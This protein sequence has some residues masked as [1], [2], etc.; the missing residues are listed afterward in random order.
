MHGYTPGR[1]SFNVKGGRC[2]ACEGD[3]VKQRRDALPARR[4]R[5]VRG[6]P[7]PALQRRDA[8]REV[9]R[10]LDRRR[11]RPHGRRGAAALQEPPEPSAARSRRSPTWA[12]ATSPS[13]SP[14]RRSPAARRSASSSRASS[15]KRSTGRTLYILDE[16]TTGL[17]FDDIR[18]LLRV[19]DRL[20]EA[21]NTVVVIEHNLDVIKTADWVIDLG[22]EGGDG[23]GSDRRRGHAGAGGGGEGL[24]TPAASSRRCCRETAAAGARERRIAPRRRRLDEKTVARPRT[25]GLARPARG[26]R[27]RAGPGPA[28]AD[29][30]AAGV[31]GARAPRV[32][33]DGWIQLRINGAPR[34]RGFQHGFLLAKEIDASLRTTR[35]RWQYRTGMTWPWLVRRSE[36]MFRGRID[37]ELRAEIDGIVGR[38]RRGRGF[39]ERGRAGGVQRASSSFPATGGRR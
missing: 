12:S 35:R 3:G 26:P 5:A 8:R 31:A 19:L 13:A 10:P 7:R 34:E 29:A 15:S 2:E 4:L 16:P 30:A 32:E 36:A 1:F 24:A 33:R 6:L 27:R 28:A 21:G 37:A 18:K 14:R 17:H 38:P 20:V 25:R 39:H 22:P 23:G 9:Q 11:A